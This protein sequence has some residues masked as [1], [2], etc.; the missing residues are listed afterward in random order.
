[1]MDFVTDILAFENPL[2]HV[3]QHRLFSF[4][5]GSLEVNF[6]NHM[7]MV[8]VAGGLMLIIFPL[9]A[10]DRS[11]VPRGLRNFIETICVFVREDIAGADTGQKCR[12]ICALSVDHVFLYPVL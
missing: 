4:H 7:L 9:V 3:V 8:L 1:M 10:R 5:I 6:S 11:M 2:S 12:Y